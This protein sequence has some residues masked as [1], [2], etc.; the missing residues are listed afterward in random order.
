MSRNQKIEEI[1][2][3]LMQTLKLCAAEKICPEEFRSLTRPLR[4]I[5]QK[6][7][8]RE[9]INSI[10]FISLVVVVV[11]VLYQV[12]A[13]AEFI[14]AVGKIGMVKLVLPYWDWTTIHARDCLFENPY[15]EPG[16]ITEEDCEPL[17]NLSKVERVEN[18]S[19]D[20][21]TEDHLF[22]AVPVIV[23]DAMTDWRAVKDV[24]FGVE[25]IA[26]LYNDDPI[27]SE[28]SVCSVSGLDMAS[29]LQ[30]FFKKMH[31]LDNFQVH[32]G[33]CKLPAAKVL[34]QYYR[35]PYFLPGMVEADPKN[36]II[37]GGRNDEETMPE[38]RGFDPA[39]MQVTWVS[40]V[41]GQFKFK[42]LPDPVCEEK[43]EELE[44]TLNEGETLVYC[45]DFWYLQ[46]SAGPIGISLAIS[47]GGAW[48]DL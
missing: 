38:Y 42:L 6:W 47:S 9:R 26:E 22:I 43:C 19:Q 12:E 30:G 14:S 11:A 17:V 48:E 21:M 2:Q 32:W 24:N 29:T 45:N 33:H 15:R 13:T 7:R 41:K 1:D 25:Y 20:A 36:F 28:T 44:G 27:L 5:H 40:Q 16:G 4:M 3:K 39:N 8:R 46:Y 10:I 34:R 23:T 31:T 18:L 35:R 37:V